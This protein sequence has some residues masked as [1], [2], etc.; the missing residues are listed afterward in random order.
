MV[1]VSSGEPKTG[2]ATST[3]D[4]AIGPSVTSSG[5][6]PGLAGPT[7]KIQ[8]VRV[9]GASHGLKRTSMADVRVPTTDERAVVTLAEVQASTSV[10]DRVAAETASVSPTGPRSH[11]RSDMGNPSRPAPS[12]LG[13]RWPRPSGRNI[14]GRLERGGN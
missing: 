6:L 4:G 2:M 10:W 8:I 14:S 13:F 9:S 5:Y 12:S 1:S 3:F 11:P 7:K